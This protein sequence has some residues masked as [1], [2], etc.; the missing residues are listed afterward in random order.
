MTAGA[1]RIPDE[2]ERLVYARQVVA[3]G[4]DPLGRYTPKPTARTRV[5]WLVWFYDTPAGVEA[6]QA[7][8][9]SGGGR[10]TLAAEFPEHLRAFL[11]LVPGERVLRDYVREEGEP[12]PAESFV[13]AGYQL[14]AWVPLHYDAELPVNAASLAFARRVLAR[15][16]IGEMGRMT[17]QTKKAKAATKTFPMTE[18]A[19]QHHLSLHDGFCLACGAIA[20]QVEPDA[21]GYPCRGCGEPKVYGVEELLLRGSIAIK[22]NDNG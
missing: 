8:R 1:M 15:R 13:R 12:D 17:S 18:R 2:D 11:R 14:R 5:A 6:L 3:T 4:E 16:H 20:G 10:I 22:E 19:Y 7:K 9:A 21:R